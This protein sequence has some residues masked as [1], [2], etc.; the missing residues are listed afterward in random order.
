MERKAKRTG[1]RVAVVEGLVVGLVAAAAVAVR[2]RARRKEGFRIHAGSVRRK[3]KGQ[4]AV[5]S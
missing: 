1:G 4:V 3:A 5:V 2:R